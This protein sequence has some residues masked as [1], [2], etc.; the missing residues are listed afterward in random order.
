MWFGLAV[1]GSDDNSIQ[2]LFPME[3]EL[4]VRARTHTKACLLV[5]AH[6]FIYAWFTVSLPLFQGL[7]QLVILSKKCLYNIGPFFQQLWNMVVS[8]CTQGN[9]NINQI[10]LLLHFIRPILLILKIP[11]TVFST[12]HCSFQTS[13]Y[14]LLNHFGMFLYVSS[15]IHNPYCYR[16]SL[17]LDPQKEIKSG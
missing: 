17:L 1:A 10:N 4:C 7:I 3:R 11:A 14:C 8:R 16:S 5:H 9:K 6:A 2:H 15:S 12:Q 13:V